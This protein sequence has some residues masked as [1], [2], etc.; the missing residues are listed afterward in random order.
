VLLKQIGQAVISREA[1]VA[2]ISETILACQQ[3]EPQLEEPRS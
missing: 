1:S 3:P 2:Q